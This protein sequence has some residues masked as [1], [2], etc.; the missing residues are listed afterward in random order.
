MLHCYNIVL[1]LKGGDIMLE[2][3]TQSGHR[4]RIRLVCT[5]RDETAKQMYTLQEVYQVPLGRIVDVLVNQLWSAR[6][7]KK[8][9]CIIGGQCPYDKPWIETTGL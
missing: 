6:A 2:N 4:P 7:N 3:D 9:M 5:V 1:C 8:M